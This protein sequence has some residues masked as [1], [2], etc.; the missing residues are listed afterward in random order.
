MVGLEGASIHPSLVAL[1]ASLTL[2]FLRAPWLRSTERDGGRESLRT[3]WVYFEWSHP[4]LASAVARGTAAA[5]LLALAVGTW[6]WGPALWHSDPLGS[7]HNA[8]AF[9]GGL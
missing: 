6:T 8:L 5:G 9:V 3:K 7:L 2:S 1:G 4:F